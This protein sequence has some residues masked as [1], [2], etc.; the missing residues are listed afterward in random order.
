[1]TYWPQSIKSRLELRFNLSSNLCDWFVSS[2]RMDV[3]WPLRTTFSALA[4]STL[5]P[6]RLL[7]VRWRADPT[8]EVETPLSCRGIVLVGAEKPIVLCGRLMIANGSQ[9]EF[10]K[11][12][13]NAAATPDRVAIH[14]LISMM[15]LR[16][17][18][19]SDEIVEKH[20]IGYR[21]FDSKLPRGD[22]WRF[23]PAV[24]T[25][26]AEAKSVTHLGLSTANVKQV[27]SNRRILGPDGKVA[28]VRYTATKDAKIRDFPEGTI[29][30]ALADDHALE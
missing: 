13:A 23:A 17:D 8:I 2:E 16:C 9:R 5:T 30:P 11:A 22:R 18:F 12:I 15:H 29:D 28:Y 24:K 27:T 19:T 20:K 6:R 25:A 21:P 26:V 3:C 10:K 4:F 1:M 14:T 7:G